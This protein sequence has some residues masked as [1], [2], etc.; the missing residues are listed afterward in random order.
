MSNDAMNQFIRSAT[1]RTG[2]SPPPA[3]IVA[4]ST[5]NGQEATPPPQGAT[6]PNV[7]AHLRGML[8]EGQGRAR[9]SLP[10]AGAVAFNVAARKAGAKNPAALYAAHGEKV[11]VD[12]LGNVHGDVDVLIAQLKREQPALFMRFT[13]DGGAGLGDATGD[14]TTLNPARGTDVARAAL[15]IHRR[16]RDG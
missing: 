7:S 13:I 6:K 5:P 4:A 10:D 9:G 14:A 2:A 15:D 8:H 11:I 1:G 16:Y 3:T 12:L